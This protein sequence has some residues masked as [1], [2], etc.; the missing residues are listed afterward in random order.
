M[1]IASRDPNIEIDQLLKDKS[2]VPCN[3]RQG[4]VL[5]ALYL[6]HGFLGVPQ[7]RLCLTGRGRH[8]GTRASVRFVF[9]GTCWLDFK[10]T[11]TGK[12]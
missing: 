4:H 3:F 8:P 2:G 1:A 11:P 7:R 10:R 6:S 12:P 5:G 9:W